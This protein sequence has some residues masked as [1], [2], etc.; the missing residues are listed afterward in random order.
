[1][2]LLRYWKERDAERRA[3]I[4][5]LTQQHQQEPDVDG[6]ESFCTHVGTML[7]KLTPALRIEAKSEVFN[8]LVDYEVKSLNQ[9]SSNSFNS[10]PADQ[11]S[12]ISL[13]NATD[14]SISNT[15]I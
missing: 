1:M 2:A 9:S 6:I 7:R 13:Q 15:L 5:T 12:E 14:L 11:G 10:S 8:L 3:D 4:Q